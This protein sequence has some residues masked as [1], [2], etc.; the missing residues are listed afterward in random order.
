MVHSEQ[1]S[2]YAR[3]DWQSFLRENG[4][5]GRTRRQRKCCDDAIDESF[6]QLLKWEQDRCHVHAIREEARCD[7]LDYIEVL[8]NARRRSGFNNQLSPAK[9]EKRYEKQPSS[10]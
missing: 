1:G 3:Y 2:Q 9:Y 6:F 8:N 4:L 10:G 5:E 7:V